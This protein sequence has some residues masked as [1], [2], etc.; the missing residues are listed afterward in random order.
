MINRRSFIEMLGLTAIGG[1][2]LAT[3]GKAFGQTFISNDL[4]ALPSESLSDPVFSFTSAHFTPFIDTDFEA[5]A[6][7]DR[8][9]VRLLRLLNVKEV[10]R[11]ENMAKGIQGDSFS[12]M[13][14]DT[15][16]RQLAADRYEFAHPSLGAFSLV[17][18][19]V[20]AELNRY[21]AVINHL[22]R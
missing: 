22:R 7:G 10:L 3:A 16:G 1:A 18:M 19:P 15:R 6:D 20:S 4:F 5:R 11:K 21:E 2:S 8:R 13:F 17:L 14:A 9:G 12:L